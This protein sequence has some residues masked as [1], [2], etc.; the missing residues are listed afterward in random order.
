LK[1]PRMSRVGYLAQISVEDE[2]ASPKEAVTKEGRREMPQKAHALRVGIRGYFTPLDSKVAREVDVRAKKSLHLE[3]GVPAGSWSF[4]RD[5]V[6][7]H[8]QFV[9]PHV[10]VIGGEKDANI[11]RE[12]GD[13]KLLRAEVR[14]EDVERGAVESG[15][16]RLE[17]EKVLLQRNQE[18]RDRSTQAFATHTMLNLLP[19]VILPPTEIVVHVNGG[20]ALRAQTLLRCGNPPRRGQCEAKQLFA[21]GEGKVIDHI[22]EKQRDRSFSL[23]GAMRIASLHAIQLPASCGDGE[24]PQLSVGVGT[25]AILDEFISG[26]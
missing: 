21:F 20:H 15:M 12:A 9:F 25:S 2:G 14:K 18:P 8:H 7:R 3:A 11:R 19:K 23:G 6:R 26:V 1:Y 16:L 22:N 10:G 4:R 24:P 5:A 17:H 13:D